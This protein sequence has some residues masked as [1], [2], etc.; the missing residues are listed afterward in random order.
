MYRLYVNGKSAGGYGKID[1]SESSFLK[2]T[3]LDIGDYVTY[4]GDNTL[5]LQVHDWVGSGGLNGNV[6]LTTGPADE[7]LELLKR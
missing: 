4:G 5:A 1:R 6:W 7:A 2:R 3:W